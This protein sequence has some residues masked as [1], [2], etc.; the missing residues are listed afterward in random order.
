MPKI[1]VIIPAYNQADYLGESIQSVLH[2][3]YKDFEIVVVDDG[4]TDNTAQVVRE[5]S[6]PRVGY[7]Y[8]ENRGLAGAR[9]TGIR[10][11]CGQ[12]LSFLDS[13]DLFLPENLSLLVTELENN[14]DV[15]FVSGQVIPVDENG[16]PV[17]KI[18]E[19]HLPSDP[20]FLLL[21]N[22]VQ[23]GCMM[24][25]RSHQEKVG[26]FDESL[27]SYEDWDMWLRLARAGCKMRWLPRPVSEYR[28]HTGQM[29][30]IGNQM[31]EAT[32]KVLDKVFADPSLPESWQS[33]KNKAY[34]NACLRAAAQAYLIRDFERACGYLNRAVE[35]NPDLLCG[36]ARVLADHFI[37]WTDLPKVQQP[38]QFLE[39][40]FNHLP[41]RIEV[42]RQNR[43]EHLGRAA[44]QM[45]FQAYLN[46]DYKATR[47][48][49][50]HAI[51]YQPYWLMN[52]GAL[53]IFLRS[54]FK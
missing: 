18:F 12:Y 22:P 27:R 51:R 31:T 34:S 48:A 1:S 33:L 54:S 14:P 38:F 17:G 43:R 45:A 13:D 19:N 42:L 36:D 9:N 11:S 16:K 30:R 35:L 46:G 53:S 41:E 20:S 4:S 29:T 3:D 15:G 47:S 28:F 44:I 24:L 52:R 39:G 7:V 21:G 8:Q 25:R 26:Y 10:N 40:I 2:Q 5:F 6:D 50:L 37:S 49:V 23:V 32:F